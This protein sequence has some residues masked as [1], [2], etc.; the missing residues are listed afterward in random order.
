MLW[1]ICIAHFHRFEIVRFFN[2][3]FCGGIFVTATSL[4]TSSSTG[5]DQICFFGIY[6]LSCWLQNELVRI[7]NP[8]YVMK[9]ENPTCSG[10][11]LQ[12]PNKRFLYLELSATDSEKNTAASEC[13]YGSTASPFMGETACD[14]AFNGAIGT[15][16]PKPVRGDSRYGRRE[17]LPVVEFILSHVA[18]V[19]VCFVFVARLFAFRLIFFCHAIL[20]DNHWS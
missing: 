7:T 19:V 1:S 3:L 20:Q 5:W 12:F 16:S 14:W 17:L 18:I 9:N 4:S 8:N 11:K 2:R 13:E 15:E 10:K 6:V